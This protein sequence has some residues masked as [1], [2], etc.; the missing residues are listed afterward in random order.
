MAVVPTN[1][2]DHNVSWVGQAVHICSPAQVAVASAV[3]LSS[4]L[5]LKQMDFWKSG[6]FYSI[7]LPCLLL[8]KRANFKKDILVSP[9]GTTKQDLRKLLKTHRY[10]VR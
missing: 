4:D 8:L 7:R 6:T 1:P 10:H 9:D 3:V 5:P 2:G